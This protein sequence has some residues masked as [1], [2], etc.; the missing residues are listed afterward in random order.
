MRLHRLSLRDVKGVRERTVAFPASGIV[1]IEGPNEVGKTTL[2]EAFDALLDPA[3][4]ATSKHSRVKALQPVGRDVGPTVEAEFSVG[5]YRLRLLKRWLRSPRTELEVLAPA[6][7]LHTGEAAQQRV[8]EILASTLDRALW[9]ALRFTQAGAPG[10]APLTDSAVLTEALDGA[11]GAD[12]H[13]TDG[14]ALLDQV[15]QEY[16]R[17]YTRTGR[18]T[19]VLRQALNAVTTAR[20]EAVQAFGRVQETDQLLDRHRQARAAV[21]RLSEQQPTLAQDVETATEA[22]RVAAAAVEAHESAQDG[23]TRAADALD[24]ATQAL[25]ER[26]RL[27]T[28]IADADTRW[29]RAEEALAADRTQLDSLLAQTEELRTEVDTRRAAQQRAR[30]VWD[31]AAADEA[32][33]TRAER[34]GKLRARLDRLGELRAAQNTAQQQLA[35]HPA[36]DPA[37]LTELEQHDLTVLRLRSRQ[38]ASSSH[39]VLEALGEGVQ[40]LVNG[41]P[42]TLAEVESTDLSVAGGLELELPGALR[43]TVRP[44]QAAAELAHQVTEAE[45]A[46]AAAFTRAGV[47][48]VATARAAATTR[49]ELTARLRH[50]RDRVS[51]LLEGAAEEQVTQ[52]ATSLEEEVETY[53][54]T[55][56]ADRMLAPDVATARA[57][58]RAARRD[59]DDLSAEVGA[60]ERTLRQ[61]EQHCTTLRS[62]VDNAAGAN[63]SLAGRLQQDRDRLVTLRSAEP[64]ATLEE[65]V[66]VATR[67]RDQ[68]ETVAAVARRRAE[69]ADPGGAREALARADQAHRQHAAA[70]E[71]ARR[72]LS[73]LD[74]QVELVSGEGRQ[75]T[76]DEAVAEFVRLRTE[77]EAVHRRARAAR[78]LHETLGRHRESAHSAYVRPYRQELERLGRQV[79]GAGFE[80]EVAPD[81]TIR[82]RTL[83]G[84]TVPF[85]QLSGGAQEQL[86]I[87][88]RLAVSCLVEAG[89]TVPVII[90][91]ALGYTDPDRLEQVSTV[92]GGPGERS[93]VI[94]LTCTPDRYA[95]IPHSTTI[96]L[97]A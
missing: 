78:Q 29:E 2:L 82:T 4:K 41:E 48:D 76:Y 81:L 96:Q 70:L 87:L 40:L 8:D 49:E 15:E 85:A 79:Y 42:V 47:A 9:E 77:L 24:H 20:D 33:L 97:T 92:F 90:D 22:A 58:V 54:A 64:D 14:G 1:V 80:V 28:E 51:D 72:T 52:E 56:P 93:Q 6:R 65:T 30:T 69:A 73:E 63:E 84:Q 61:H 18:T 11:S 95:Q 34:A 71:A 5:D 26:Q 50:L 68:A 12:L 13:S 7:E 66:L 38:E 36:I 10:Q 16:L 62:R 27:V 31:A 17:Y 59:L 45:H 88:S 21:R 53:A 75:E 25:S 86:G 60:A 35:E 37:T 3:L 44:E 74:G 89:D 39:V 19:G 43:V 91:D 23:V 57:V 67:S 46:R 83:D 32:H 94:L 55:R